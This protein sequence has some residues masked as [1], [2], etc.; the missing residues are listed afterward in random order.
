MPLLKGKENIGHNIT[1]MEAAGHSKKQAI[2]AALH[3]AYGNKGMK[4][5]PGLSKK[6]K[7]FLG[8]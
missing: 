4:R 8:G 5:K 3:T 6:G 2:A 7:G 1:E